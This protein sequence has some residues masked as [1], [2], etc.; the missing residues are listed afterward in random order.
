MPSLIKQFVRLNPA[1]LQNAAIAGVISGN[2]N[3]KKRK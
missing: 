2:K 1:L 3:H